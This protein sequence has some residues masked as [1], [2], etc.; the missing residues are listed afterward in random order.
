MVGI[1]WCRTSDPVPLLRPPPEPALPTSSAPPARRPLVRWPL[2]GPLT[3][4]PSAHSYPISDTPGTNLPVAACPPSTLVRPSPLRLGLL[5]PPT[6]YAR[7]PR[8]H[9]GPH[10][11][12]PVFFAGPHPWSPESGNS[13]SS[14]LLFPVA[15]GPHPVHFLRPPLLFRFELSPHLAK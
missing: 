4:T 6:S 8:L 13:Q 5:H 10:G 11:R 3:A 2:S 12:A 1:K 14:M 7:S 9:P 15:P